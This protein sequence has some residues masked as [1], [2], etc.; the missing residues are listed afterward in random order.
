LS[1]G[2]RV[3]EQFLRLTLIHGIH[4][5]KRGGH[6]HLRVFRSKTAFFPLFSEKDVQNWLKMGYAG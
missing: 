2:C 3:R 1:T 4:V 5:L 6:M